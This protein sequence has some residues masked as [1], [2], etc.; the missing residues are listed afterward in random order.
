MNKAGI[1]RRMQ[2]DWEKRKDILCVDMGLPRTGMSYSALALVGIDL[3]G[4]SKKNEFEGFANSQV[5]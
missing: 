3:N 2:E 1:I 5:G 4:R